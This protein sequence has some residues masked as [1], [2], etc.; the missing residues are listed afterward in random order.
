MRSTAARR[1]IGVTKENQKPFQA[2][3]PS[4]SGLPIRPDG[5]REP[6]DRIAFRSAGVHWDLA[7]AITKSTNSWHWKKPVHR[8]WPCPAGSQTRRTLR[9]ETPRPASGAFFQAGL[10]RC[11]EPR[12]LARARRQ[13]ARRGFGSRTSSINLSWSVSS[14]QAASALSQLDLGGS[15]ARQSVG[16]IQRLAHVL[17]N[18]ATTW[19][20][21][22]PENQDVTQR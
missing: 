4:R 7:C 9:H 15:H 17:A 8:L 6:H 22:Q 12:R 21:Q 20:R 2:R 1:W 3:P 16:S 19:L 14:K 13:A 18:V 10:S 5:P 11:S